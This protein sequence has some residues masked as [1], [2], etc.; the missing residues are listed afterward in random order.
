[1]LTIIFC[2]FATKRVRCCDLKN[3]L[4]RLKDMYALMFHDRS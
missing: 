1:M 4:M 3:I 2:L